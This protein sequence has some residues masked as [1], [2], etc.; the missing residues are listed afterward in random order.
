M[1]KLSMGYYLYL[2]CILSN[3]KPNIKC[4]YTGKRYS[5][6]LALAPRDRFVGGGPIYPDE[7]RDAILAA[8]RADPRLFFA[9]LASRKWHWFVREPR[10]MTD[11]EQWGPE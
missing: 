8:E 6:M 7:V 1:L 10:D 4:G 9:D 3:S 2:A 11:E 5:Y